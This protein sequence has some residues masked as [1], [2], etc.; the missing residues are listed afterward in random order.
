MKVWFIAEKINHQVITAY[1]ILLFFFRSMVYNIHDYRK[2]TNGDSSP[3]D[4]LDVKERTKGVEELEHHHCTT[5]LLMRNNTADWSGLWQRLWA[6]SEERERGGGGREKRGMNKRCVDEG[7][8][9]WR[10]YNLHQVIDMHL[11]VS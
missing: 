5:K 2:L 11:E 8:E 1:T 9:G 7:E 4:L 3:D 6:M 10:D